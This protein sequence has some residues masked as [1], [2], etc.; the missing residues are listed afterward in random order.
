MTFYVPTQHQLADIFTKA[1]SCITSVLI[2][3]QQDRTLSIYRVLRI[4]IGKLVL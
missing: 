4:A 1:S 2:A 3:A